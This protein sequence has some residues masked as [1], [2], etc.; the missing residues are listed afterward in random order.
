M[1]WRQWLTVV[2]VLAPMLLG[3]DR[4][5][6]CAGS[7]RLLRVNGSDGSLSPNLAVVGSTRTLSE[8]LLS[9]EGPYSPF[10]R[11]QWRGD[12]NSYV[13]VVDVPVLN[14]GVDGAPFASVVRLPYPASAFSP[15]VAEYEPGSI[16]DAAPLPPQVPRW[17]GARAL[18]MYDRGECSSAVSW[19]DLGDGFADGFDRVLREEQ[20][21]PP[22]GSWISTYVLRQEF[23][24]ERDDF[25][26]TRP[27]SVHVP[28]TELRVRVAFTIRGRFTVVDQQLAY[29]LLEGALILPDGTRDALPADVAARIEPAIAEGVL[30]QLGQSLRGRLPDATLRCLPEEGGDM[31][32]FLRVAGALELAA[33][34]PPGSA[35]P[36]NLRCLGSGPVGDCRY[37]P[38]VYR[39]NHRVDGIEVVLSEE[40]RFFVGADPLIGLLEEEEGVCHGFE[41][42]PASPAVCVHDALPEIHDGSVPLCGDRV[43][44]IPE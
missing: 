36:H 23:R 27:Y 41:V 8:V 9:V 31:D 25:T 5:V 21:A 44:A 22:V 6:G 42:G 38:N 16:F 37:V 4:P 1:S 43:L 24:G 26:W 20:D 15:L 19:R 17:R 35:Q 39:V 32:C 33:G 7:P 13:D 40:E 18:R 14:Q 34:A 11:V 12:P 30:G 2:A 29:R 28:T 10:T 3:V